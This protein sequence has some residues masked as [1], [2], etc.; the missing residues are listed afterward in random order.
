[1]R[2]CNLKTST[3]SPRKLLR[4]SPLSQE[5]ITTTLFFDMLV[6]RRPVPVNE[7]VSA[8]LKN[9]NAQ[10]ATGISME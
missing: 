5:S 3:L 10:S 4:A 9:Y 2:D 1:M 6:P 7:D 8:I